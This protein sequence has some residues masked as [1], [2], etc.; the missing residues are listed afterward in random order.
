MECGILF[1]LYKGRSVYFHASGGS[2]EKDNVTHIWPQMGGPDTPPGVNLSGSRTS[3][4]HVSHVRGASS[5]YWTFT[6][7]EEG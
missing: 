6:G 1:D 4:P 7:Q 3:V 5:F 2:V